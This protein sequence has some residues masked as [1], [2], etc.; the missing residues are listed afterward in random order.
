MRFRPIFMMLGW[1][2]ISLSILM[3]F[4]L[5][6]E[7]TDYSHQRIA[8]TFLYS[9]IA[10]I[11]IGG[12]IIFINQG[13]IKDINHR[14]AF[15]ITLLAWGV[16][17]SI[18]AIPFWLSS[19]E[20]TYGLAFFE[21]MSGI[22]TTGATILNDIDNT[23]PGILLW[24]SILQWLGGLGI[25]VFAIVVLPILQVGGM[26]LFRDSLGSKNDKALPRMTEVGTKITIFYTIVTM[27]CAF[28]YYLAGM[29]VFDS[30]N[31]AMTTLSTGGFSTR[32]AS[33][34]F[35]QKPAIELVAA[36]FMVIGSLPF[37]LY[38][39]MLAG[40][41]KSFFQDSQIQCFFIIMSVVI[42][43]FVISMMINTDKNIIEAILK[44]IFNGISILTGTGYA[45]DD[46][47][48]WGNLSIALFFIISLIGG[49]AG[50]TSCGLKIF[51][52]QII[53]IHI[54]NQ[55][56]K[57]VQPNAIFIDHYNKKTMSHDITLSVINF[58]LL[59]MMTL[60]L[61]ALALAATDLDFLTAFSSA[62]S[63]LANVGPALGQQVGPT[64][65]FSHFSETAQWIMCFG[66]LLGR[67]E[68]ITFLVIF[69][70]NY[71]YK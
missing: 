50:S 52:L 58:F 47:L 53:F 68:I 2:I 12:L 15:L 30:V 21:A 29:S 49:C 7:L 11:F 31:H 10:G 4:P 38:L 70:K 13:K 1:T 67:L 33:I 8:D 18:A 14:Q 64:G 59:Y 17:P 65:N 44:A 48:Q 42:I 69:S 19:S 45:S 23:A 46:Y 3:I 26:Q 20:L 36:F 66:M 6:V 25:I 34:G 54:T 43:L 40:S 37:L 35:Y 71:W 39:T 56:R 55:V 16:T 28:C 9:I 5:I 61:L 24:R 57:L 62:A 22:T 51:R 41:I 32:D 60:F 63:S 27:L